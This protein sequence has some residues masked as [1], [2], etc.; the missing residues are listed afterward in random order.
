[1]M[2][3]KPPTPSPRTTVS[4]C[5]SWLQGV[6]RLTIVITDG[7]EGDGDARSNTDLQNMTIMSTIL[8]SAKKKLENLRCIVCQG[9]RKVWVRKPS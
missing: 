4:S 6:L 5:N 2:L 8:G 9:S 1:M 7:D 3:R